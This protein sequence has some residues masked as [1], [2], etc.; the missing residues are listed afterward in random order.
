MT[1]TVPNVPPHASFDTTVRAL[2]ELTR[3]HGLTWRLG[4]GAVLLD[5][6]FDRDIKTKADETRTFTTLRSTLLPKP[7]S[8]GICVPEAERALK[9]AL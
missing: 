4:I 8:G 7:A 2:E 6:V 1:T 3:V 5:G 9:D